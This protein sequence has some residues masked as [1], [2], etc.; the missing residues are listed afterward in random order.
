MYNHVS[1][2][3]SCLA[4]SKTTLG[5]KNVT[6]QPI[7]RSTQISERIFRIPPFWHNMQSTIIVIKNS[8]FRWV[9]LKISPICFC[10]NSKEIR[11]YNQK[12]SSN[13][14]KIKQKFCRLRLIHSEQLPEKLDTS[15]IFELIILGDELEISAI[16]GQRTHSG[17]ITRL[18]TGKHSHSR[19][20][21]F[22]PLWSTASVVQKPLSVV[23]DNQKIV[24]ALS[25]KISSHALLSLTEL[26]FQ[27]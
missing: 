22:S 8:I 1:W 6:F 19:S 4:V 20:G 2:G 13:F 16:L 18:S 23:D 9:I 5:E 3:G 25:V 10:R 21:N 14:L 7:S 27:I 11:G 24:G 26:A 12:D 15:S 17:C